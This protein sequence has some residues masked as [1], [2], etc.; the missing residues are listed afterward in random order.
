M[1]PDGNAAQ[2]NTETDADR[3]DAPATPVPPRRSRLV[4]FG[5]VAVVALALDV[6]SK[7]L[8]VRDLPE[9][10]EHSVGHAPVRVL[11]GVFYL[12]QARNS[13]AAFSLGAGFTIVLTIVALVVVVLIV[14]FAQRLRSIGWAISLG[15][16]LGGA[17][18]NLTDRVFRSPGF[19]RGRVVDWIS[20]FGAYGKHWPIFNLADSAIVCGAVL[21]AVLA[22]FGVELD[23]E[24]PRRGP[25]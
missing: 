24:R 6:V 13:G 3:D 1:T 14:R 9:P 2:P 22:I 4:L 11:G 20:L 18:G 8:V 10:S 16:I 23:G 25:A 7:F 15:L 19:L 5:A 21:A 17:L 12:D